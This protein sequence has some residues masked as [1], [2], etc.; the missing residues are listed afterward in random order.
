MNK[1]VTTLIIAASLST[2]SSFSYA[3]DGGRYGDPATYNDKDGLFGTSATIIDA[4]T[5]VN[6]ADDQN[7]IALNV[8]GGA[9][10][11]TAATY[12]D[13]EGLFGISAKSRT[14]KDFY[15]NLLQRIESG[16]VALRTSRN[17]DHFT[18][19]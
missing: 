1:T 14:F 11:G 16:D 5:D 9:R 4:K 10:Y 18:G 2:M 19:N 15:G 12:N 7:M 6:G 17:M 13:K 8:A 3:A